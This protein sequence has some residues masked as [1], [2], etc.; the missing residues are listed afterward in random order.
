MSLDTCSPGS[1]PHSDRPNWQPAET[2]EQY[3]TNCRE[4]LET[5]SRRRLAKL[6][7]V[8][9]AFLWRANLMA[10]MPEELFERLVAGGKVSAKELA[11][12]ALFVRRICDG[13]RPSGEI[14]RCPHCG[15][16]V[17]GISAKSADILRE[18][19]SELRARAEP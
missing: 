14:E 12:V 2:P 15:E 17:R 16:R 9:R 19:H 11:K 13:E 3:L 8:S 4:G 1:H 5:F 18:W 7:G 6:M 10:E